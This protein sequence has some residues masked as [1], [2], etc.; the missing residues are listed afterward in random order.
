M[1]DPAYTIA[2]QYAKDLGIPAAISQGN[3]WADLADAVEDAAYKEN[4]AAVASA[5][6]AAAGDLELQYDLLREAAA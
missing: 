5:F 2:L 4:Y 1:H 6:W 3:K